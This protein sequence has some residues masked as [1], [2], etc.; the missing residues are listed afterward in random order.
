MSEDRQKT[1]GGTFRQLCKDLKDMS[2]MTSSSIMRDKMADKDYR[3]SIQNLEFRIMD[4]IMDLREQ[5]LFDSMNS[6][7]FDG[8]H[9]HW[10]EF[11][12]P[13]RWDFDENES[14][15]GL[16]TYQNKWK[17]PGRFLDD[18][19]WSA[20]RDTLLKYL[21]KFE[22][23][24]PKNHENE[25][26]WTED[27]RAD[28]CSQDATQTS[29]TASKETPNGTPSDALGSQSTAS[30]FKN[31][32]LTFGGHFRMLGKELKRL[33]EMMND[34]IHDETPETTNDKRERIGNQQ[35]LIRKNVNILSRHKF[36][37]LMG[38]G[39]S[40]S[41]GRFQ[42][43]WHCLREMSSGWEESSSNY[44]K[45]APPI[46]DVKCEKDRDTLMRIHRSIHRGYPA[47]LSYDN[48]WKNDYKADSEAIKTED[49]YLTFRG[50]YH[51]LLSDL[52]E[53]SSLTNSYDLDTLG[54][55]G[56]RR[57][58]TDIKI[59]ETRVTKI[60]PKISK[61]PLFATM[62]KYG[63]YLSHSAFMSQWKKVENLSQKW[64]DT[65][66]I[67]ENLDTIIDHRDW[68]GDHKALGEIQFGNSSPEDPPREWNNMYLP[69]ARLV[70]GAQFSVNG[71]DRPSYSRVVVR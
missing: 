70:S 5:D 48:D 61:H 68:K 36:L 18:R 37:E 71:E 51:M 69:A 24:K 64:E 17:Y 39:M 14:G 59:L 30:I 8:F 63:L 49:I 7:S 2:D 54:R 33:T 56:D 13:N 45:T 22:S 43:C 26:E 41:P 52:R 6:H 34:C 53:I 28:A 40:N 15:W 31:R 23:A 3:K 27:F 58:W 67:W 9:T 60:V 57:Y 46:D 65:A 10:S 50:T 42:R 66:S 11:K 38:A 16:D 21:H 19:D 20:D 44:N 29:H 12:L 55:D 32:I 1:F 62:G 25:P 35:I 47:H 4:A